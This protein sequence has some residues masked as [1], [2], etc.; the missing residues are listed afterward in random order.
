MKFCSGQTFHDNVVAHEKGIRERN[1]V[2]DFNPAICWGFYAKEENWTSL[3]KN[4]WVR[5]EDVHHYE[6]YFSTIKLATRMSQ[7]PL[8]VVKAYINQ[9]YIGNLL[10]LFEPN[11]TPALKGHYISNQKFPKDWFERTS[12]CKGNCQSCKYCDGVL[13]E[14]L[15]LPPKLEDEEQ[16][17]CSSA[18]SCSGKCK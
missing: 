16:L 12:A 14:V 9:R 18:T 17:D 4:T 1:N 2:E 6:G 15:T 5:P 10:D 3:L 13:K 8:A 7:R 11:H